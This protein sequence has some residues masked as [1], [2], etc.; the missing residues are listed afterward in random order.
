[1][2]RDGERR[3]EVLTKL[4]EA[5]RSLM[6]ASDR[7]T[8]GEIVI[9]TCEEVLGLGIALLA[10]VDEE[11]EELY[12]LVTSDRAE[13]VLPPLEGLRY[14]PGSLPWQLFQSEE[15]HAFVDIGEHLPEV[16]DRVG[17]AVLVPM[18]EHGLLAVGSSDAR[19]LDASD[20]DFVKT[21]AANAETAIERA[22][23][24]E[25][26]REEHSRITALF[27]NTSDA[28][29]E[30]SY[31]SIEE[32]VVEAVNPAFERTFGF[33][34]EEVVGEPVVDV[35]VPPERR[36]HVRE[37][38]EQF[39]QEGGQQYETEVQRQTAEGLRDFLLRAVS[40]DHSGIGYAIY[41]DITD[42]VA[43]ARTLDQLHETTRELV[44]AGS[45]EEV[46]QITIDAAEDILG[47]PMNGV[48]LYDA[49]RGTLVP[50]A[51][52]AE[53]VETLGERPEYGPGDGIVWEAFESQE[54][55][56]VRETDEHGLGEVPSGVES[57]IY[58]PLGR[59]GTL[60]IGARTTHHFDEVDVRLAEVL[61]A[62]A[63]VAL[64]RA[65][66]EAQLKQREEELA[67]QNDRLEQF[68]S[69]VSHDLRNPLSV[70]QGYLDLF[71]ELC[72]DDLAD[73]DDRLAHL[74]R[75]ER[76]HRRMDRLIGDL[77]ALAR[78]G[79]AVGETEP[80]ELGVVARTAWQTVDTAAATLS[81]EDDGTF[82]AD[83]DRVVELFENLFRNAIT[84]GGTDVSVTVGTTAS[85]F[86]VEDDGV[87]I[88]PDERD[89]VFEHGYTTDSEGTGFGLA[90]VQ[91]IV[92]A[93]DWAIAAVEPTGTGARFE[94]DGVDWTSN[95]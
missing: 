86:Y 95:S 75:V 91:E 42:R 5:T 64:E 57:A 7:T 53:T 63:R 29:V 9:E 36:E 68:A 4:H 44:Q 70:A 22:R 41:T 81:V 11:T 66:R 65:D 27:Q 90:I 69:V 25:R 10:V 61:A 76:A 77:L 38:L 24:E 3:E 21:L 83:R 55:K 18:G 46:S 79:N 80:V 37:W 74:E 52:T 26:L 89:G 93:H 8:I 49:D 84:H 94:V 16:D 34:R 92:T 54:T 67:R 20:V 78:Q 73:D 23:R 85:G 15:A 58:L 13:A 19:E 51:M 60:S 47:F 14:G 40:V 31:A 82:T 50:A 43:Y 1:V 2:S 72:A 62:N 48:R 6:R 17:T 33:D 71:A 32:P 30:V 88:P 45:P 87:G 39:Q 59:R 28:I 56:V 12:P 35:L